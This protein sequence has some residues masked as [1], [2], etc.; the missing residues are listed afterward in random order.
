MSQ[1]KLLRN[2]EPACYDLTAL[3][4]SRGHKLVVVIVLSVIRVFLLTNPL[5]K[6]VC[7]GFMAYHCWLF[8]AKYRFYKYIEY[9]ICKHIF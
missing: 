6:L 4:L 7:F 9:M 3:K 2:Q 1:L 5:V 8:N